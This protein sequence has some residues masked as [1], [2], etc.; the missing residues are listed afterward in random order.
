MRAVTVNDDP[1]LAWHDLDADNPDNWSED[2]WVARIE[3]TCERQAQHGHIIDPVVLA[4]LV[5]TDAITITS[6]GRVR[7]RRARSAPPLSLPEWR[8]DTG[9]V[10]VRRR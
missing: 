4:E 1:Y 3:A 5:N 9:G 2:E 7:R 6:D 8:V 10:L